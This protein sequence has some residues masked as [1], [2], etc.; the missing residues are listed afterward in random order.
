MIEHPIVH[1]KR[2]EKNQRKFSLSPLRSFVV[3]GPEVGKMEIIED[4]NQVI[5]TPCEFQCT[6]E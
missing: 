6:E 4:F 1:I 2:Q 5:R 3:N